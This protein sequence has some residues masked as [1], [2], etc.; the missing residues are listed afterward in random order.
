MVLQRLPNNILIFRAIKLFQIYLQLSIGLLPGLY[1]ILK[2]FN[3]NNPAR[4]AGKKE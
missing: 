4:S 3:M 2:G 1:V